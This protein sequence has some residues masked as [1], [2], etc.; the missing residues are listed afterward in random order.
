MAPS[1]ETKN[2]DALLSLTLANYRA[3]LQDEISTS[4]SLFFELKGRED[5]WRS[6]SN[7]GE[8]IEVPLMYEMGTAD[9]YAGYDQLDVTPKLLAIN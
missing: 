1:S 5:G 2:Y 4:N 6:V 3:T 7:L 8:R 9:F